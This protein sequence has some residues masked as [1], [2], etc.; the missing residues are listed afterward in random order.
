MVGATVNAGDDPPVM[1]AVVC[2]DGE[3][4]LWLTRASTAI[5][6]GR[7]DEAL[8]LILRMLGASPGTMATTNGVTYVPVRRL[9]LHLLRALPEKTLVAYRRAAETSAG[10]LP[11]RIGS[12]ADVEALETWC[13]AALP[14]EAS[15]EAGRVLAGYLI[16]QSRFAEARGLLLRLLDECAPEGARRAELLARLVVACARVGD[17]SQAQWAWSELRKGDGPNGWAFLEAEVRVGPQPTEPV[18]NAWRMAYG[19]PAREGAAPEAAALAAEGVRAWAMRWAVNLGPGF[20]RGGLDVECSTNLPEFL[21]VSQDQARARMTAQHLRP[22]D[23]VVF[24]GNYAWLNSFGECVVVDLESGSLQRRTAHVAEDLSQ[25][26]SSAIDGIWAFDGRLGRAASLAGG[27]CYCVEDTYR[28]MFRPAA[29][30]ERVWDGKQNVYRAFRSG[31]ALAAYDVETGRLRWRIGRDL[32]SVVPLQAQGGWAVNAVRFAAA[33]VPCG[34]VLVVPVEDSAGNFVAGLDPDRGSLVW[35]TRLAAGFPSVRPRSGPMNVTVEGAHAYLCTGNAGVSA[36]DGYDGSVRWTTLYPRAGDHVPI[37]AVG[38]DRKREITWE[39]NVVLVVD[40]VVVALPEDSAEILAMDR[41]TGTRLWTA[42]KPDGV[43]YVVGRRGTSL[44]VAGRRAVVCVDLTD[45]RERWRAPVDG[46]TGRGTLLG[47]QVLIPCDRRIL[48]LR[49]ADGVALEPAP[50]Q[51]ME[52]MPLGNLYVRG[53]HLLVAGLERFYAL[54]DAGVVLSRLADELQRQPSAGT[55]A[56]RG[57]LRAALGNGAEAVADLR[58]AWQRQRG[59]PEEAAARVALLNA[60]WQAAGEDTAGREKYCAEAQRIAVTPTEQA[61]SIWRWGQCRARAGDTNG[62]IAMYG[63]AVAAPDVALAPGG[64]EKDWGVSSHRLAARRIHALIAAQAT[65]A[66]GSGGKGLSGWPLL[67]RAA[68]DAK[69]RLDDKAGFAE[70]AALATCLPGTRAGTEAAIRAAERATAA[71]DLGMAEAILQRI[72]GL[73]TP[74]NRV[75]LARSLKELYLQMKWL[76]GVRQL[77]EDWPWVGGGTPMPDFL[78][79]T[80]PAGGAPQPPWRLRWRARLPAKASVQPGCAGLYYWSAGTNP[81]TA[82]LDL[83]TGRV[84][85]E[86]NRVF[87]T[88]PGGETDWSDRHLLR[89]FA[90]DAAGCVDVWSGRLVTHPLFQ[91]SYEWV[92]DRGG[93]DRQPVSVSRIGLA[94]VRYMPFDTHLAGVDLLTGRVIWRRGDAEALQAWWTPPILEPASRVFV[95]KHRSDDGGRDVMEI[96]LWTGEAASRRGFGL[97]EYEE[98][99]RRMSDRQ[100][101]DDPDAINRGAPVLKDRRLT[102][103]N[104]R[105]GT[106]IWSSPAELAVRGYV[107]LPGGAVAACNEANEWT[108]LDGEDGRVRFRAAASSSIFNRVSRSGD[109]IIGTDEAG[110]GTN[111]VLAVDMA[112][113]RVAFQAQLPQTLAPIVPLAIGGTDHMLVAVTG[114]EGGLWTVVNERGELM[115]SWSVPRREDLRAGKAVSYRPIVADGVLLLADYATGEVLAYEH[116]PDEKRQT[117]VAEAAP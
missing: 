1:D 61:E 87:M 8:P 68:S 92:H 16:D 110:L 7:P 106:A 91:G 47:G 96:D 20:V 89:V 28:S 107:V 18:S 93:H 34:P 17:V 79:A 116:D 46:S 29:L 53:A 114:K 39:E 51:T 19:S 94:T 67:E 95:M 43:D 75:A 88:M 97:K 62:A 85:W 45:G 65:V 11:D 73:T 66:A 2:P 113:N 5:N 70:W 64:Q 102:V 76:K 6:A 112:G 4:N 13:R 3:V 54:E 81:V 40:G 9:A 25:A 48:R 104:L 30:E 80:T 31:N 41:T 69:S 83:E 15:A 44:I 90:G 37:D 56:A 21:F 27:D 32:R 100:G 109:Y 60:F 86:T 84:R 78:A 57:A 99:G 77:R 36:L 63:S 58:E 59:M 38:R 101:R 23:D 111:N 71:G 12:P 35:R 26:S 98:W 74:A 115:K 10:R 33:P 55:F 24:A 49:I 103:G 72:L 108:V 22:S 42:R 82:C 52:G 14:G 117:R 50:A 105:T